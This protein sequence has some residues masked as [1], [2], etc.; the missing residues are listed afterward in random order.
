MDFVIIGHLPTHDRVRHKK[1]LLIRSA[2]KA[3]A[4]H[5]ANG[6]MSAVAAAQVVDRQLFSA[7]RRFQ[8]CYDMVILL[9]ETDQFAILLDQNTSFLEF[10]P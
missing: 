6:G 8:R 9:H 10:V 1:H 4:D 7:S 5:F 2:R 3:D